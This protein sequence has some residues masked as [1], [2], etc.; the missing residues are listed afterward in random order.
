MKHKKHFGEH[1][2][3][4]LPVKD[5]TLEQLQHLKVWYVVDVKFQ[6]IG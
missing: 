4:E 6:I 3:L 2:M 1:D 5:L